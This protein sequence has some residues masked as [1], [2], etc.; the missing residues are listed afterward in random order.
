MSEIE[1]F[2]STHPAFPYLG[3][4]RFMEI[5]RAAGCKIVHRPIDL[6]QAVPAAG[7]S[8]SDSAALRIRS[9]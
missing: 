9:T 6:N 5:A 2:Y 4:A 8:L 7:S 1:N 3:F